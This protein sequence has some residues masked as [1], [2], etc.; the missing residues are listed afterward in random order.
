MEAIILAGGKAERLG[1]AAGGRPKALVPIAGR[2]LA[3][4]Q[5]GLLVSAGVERVIVSCSAGTEEEFSAGLAGLG[6]EIV[7]AAEPEPLGRG[8]GLRFAAAARKEP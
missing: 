1:A 7:P 8:G 4:Y 5:V 2:P 3:A 6:A